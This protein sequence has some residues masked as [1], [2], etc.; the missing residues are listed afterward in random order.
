MADRKKTYIKVGITVIIAVFI[1]LYG[2]AFLKEIKLD[3]SE[4]DLVV[5]FDNVNGLK[6]GDPV[7]VNGVAKGKVEKISLEGDSVRI[8]F[9]LSKDVTLKKDY[10]IQVAMLELMSGKQIL[11]YPGKSPELADISRPLVG[12]KSSDVATL[13]GTMNDIGD[14]VKILS[15]KVNTSVD[16]LNKTMQSINEFVSDEH[17]RSNLRSTASNFNSA[18]RNFNVMV[19]ESRVSLKD[20]T[21]KLNSIAGEFERTITDTRPE[22]QQTL[23]DI[24]DLT[25]RVDTLAIGL[26]EFVDN[27]NDSTSTVGKLV[28]DDELYANLNKTIENINKLIIKIRKDG[29]RLRLF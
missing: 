7:S 13:I 5:Y 19:L 27:A 12:Q 14:E 1:L 15:V 28:T 22:M 4:N 20:L 26:N 24:R 21:L 25:A 29:I 16:E 17:M 23:K 11:I 6:E 2:I 9:T 18:S 8:D 10:V 3:V